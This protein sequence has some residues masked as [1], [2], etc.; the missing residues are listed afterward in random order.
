MLRGQRAIFLN[1]ICIY[2]LTIENFREKTLTDFGGLQIDTNDKI[3]I[4]KIEEQTHSVA[5]FVK[6]VFA[7]EAERG[8]NKQLP[9]N[10]TQI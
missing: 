4:P 2:S 1:C 3:S 9:L 8:K 6:R 7:S 10:R 5:L